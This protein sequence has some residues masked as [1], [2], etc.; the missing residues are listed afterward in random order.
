MR[1]NN[2]EI[3]GAGPFRLTNEESIDPGEKYRW[4]LNARNYEFQG[5][6]GFF[7]RFLPLDAA[8]M[9]NKSTDSAVVFTFNGQYEAE[10]EQS[11]ADSFEEQGITRL[12]AE[13]VGAATIDPGELVVMVKKN[14]WNADDAAR[15]RAERG[16]LERMVRGT[17]NL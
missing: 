4:P 6:K 15:Q 1:R 13:N 9:K 5:R 14:P 12:R 3:D 2:P 7:Q 10:V 11:A 8:L 16:P 17:L